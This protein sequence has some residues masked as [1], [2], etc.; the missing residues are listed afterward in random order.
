MRSLICAVLAARRPVRSGCAEVQ[1]DAGARPRLR[2][3]NPEL[4]RLRRDNA[5]YEEANAIF[6]DRVGFL[7]GELDRPAR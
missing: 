3:K 6:K 2:P 1:V 7:R 4:K 5:G